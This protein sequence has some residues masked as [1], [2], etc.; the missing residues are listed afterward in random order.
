MK[1]YSRRKFIKKSGVSAFASLAASTLLN[2]S[3]DDNFSTPNSKGEYMGGFSAPKMN[4]IK[5][6]YIGLG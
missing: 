4:K 5:A 6:A 2:S 1:N 3:C